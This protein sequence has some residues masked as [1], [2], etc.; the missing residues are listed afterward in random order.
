MSAQ[1]LQLLLERLARDE[2]RPPHRAFD[3]DEIDDE[4]LVATS[5]LLGEACAI[6]SCEFVL[7]DAYVKRLP[8]C[9]HA[10][11]E[12]CLAKWLAK[13]NSCPMCRLD[14]DRLHNQDSRPSSRAHGDGDNDGDLP[15]A[16]PASLF[17]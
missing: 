15:C 10:F 3:I 12:D 17:L 2:H 11:H 4:D 16:P 13:S 7:K 6:C 9:R 5:K 14:L 8:K 1:H